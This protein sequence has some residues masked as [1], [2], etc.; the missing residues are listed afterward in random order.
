MMKL[1]ILCLLCSYFV[2]YLVL[3]SLSSYMNHKILFYIR[4]SLE[5]GMLTFLWHCE[6]SKQ[7]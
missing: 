4:L 5:L 1:E 2:S 3:S 6:F 7:F